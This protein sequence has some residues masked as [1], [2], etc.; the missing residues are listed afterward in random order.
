MHYFK[1]NI[2]DYHKKAGRLSM[3]EHGAYTLLLDSC[4]DRERF[5]TFDD[6]IE[7][8]W[9]R[10]EDEIAAVKFVLCKFFILED[11][12]YVQQRIKDELSK[13]HENSETNAR[14]AKAREEARR[15]IRARTVNEPPPNQEPRTTN[16]EPLTIDI[17]PKRKAKTSFPKQFIPTA[18]HLQF[19]LENKI[20]ISDE[21]IGFRLHHEAK[22]TTSGNWNSSFSTWLRNAVKF[23]RPEKKGFNG[24]Q[25]A[26]LE[27]ARQIMGERNGNDRQIIDIAS[28]GTIEGYGAR[29]PEITSGLWQ[30][31]DE[32]VAGD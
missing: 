16:Q 8:T 32:Q 19:A 26:R 13:Y 23:K 12:F 24:V 21:L 25:D 3:L 7:W 14:I 6:A 27:V 17:P 18:E 10:S 11:G 28:T 2:G 29:I 22:L 15:T 1:R 4:Y 20:N 31:D 30:P 9:A 5:P